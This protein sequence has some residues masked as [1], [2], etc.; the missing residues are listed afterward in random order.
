MVLM[1]LRTKAVFSIGLPG[2]LCL[3]LPV[4][5]R[6]QT[7]FTYTGNPY[8]P[9]YGCGGNYVCNGTTPFITISFTTTL[10]LSQLANLTQGGSRIHFCNRDLL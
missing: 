3:I 10:S 2:L 7:T 9:S 1:N 5:M 6:A 4:S 8:P